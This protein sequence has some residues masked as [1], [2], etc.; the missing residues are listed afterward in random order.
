M[1]RI[2]ISLSILAVLLA[3]ASRAQ[4]LEDYDEFGVVDDGKS[5]DEVAPD[6]GSL[7]PSMPAPDDEAAEAPED[8]DAA[9]DAGAG[10]VVPPTPA[11]DAIARITPPAD[12][13]AV[14]FR[15]LTAALPP[16]FQLGDDADD[17]RMWFL[18]DMATHKGVIFGFTLGSERDIFPDHAEIHVDRAVTL[19]GVAY[20]WREITADLGDG[21]MADLLLL[22]SVDPVDGDESQL[23]TGTTIGVSFEENRQMLETAIGTIRIGTAPPPPETQDGT[24]LDGL[25]IY[26]VPEDWNVLTSQ[27][28]LQ[29]GFW[30]Q[31]YS[32]YIG[33]ARGEAVTGIDGLQHDIPEDIELQ[34]AE[35]L[36]QIADSYYWDGTEDEFQFGGAMVPGMFTYYRLLRCV[37]GDPVMVTLVGARGW[38]WEDEFYAVLDGITLDADKLTSCSR[39]DVGS[40]GAPL[41]QEDIPAAEPSVPVAAPVPAP[42]AAAAAVTGSPVDVGGVTFLLPEGWKVTY[43]TQDD[44]Q[45]VSPDGRW[46]LLSFWWLPDEP[47]LGY[48]DITSVENL[49]L[50]HEPVMR[51]SSWFEGFRTVQTVTERARSDGKRFMFTVEGQSATDSEITS[52]VAALTANLHLQGGFDP[53]KM[54]DPLAAA[55]LATQPAAPSTLA[56][57]SPGGVGRVVDFADG[58]QGWIGDH[59]TLTAERS[60]GPSGGGVLKA[61]APGDGVNGYLIAPPQMLGD[62]V[63]AQGMTVTIRTESGTYVAPFDYGGRGDIY[64]ESRGRTAAIDFP[65]PVG[66][67]WTTEAIRFDAPGWRLSGAA[68]MAELLADVTALHVRIEFLSGDATAW[69]SR[70]ELVGGDAAAALVPPNG[71]AGWT[72]YV[73][74]R[75]GTTIEYPS[76]LLAMQQAPD[77]DDGRTFRSPDGTVTLLV[78]GQ[79]NIDGLDGPAMVARDRD[80]GDYGEVTY[81]SAK[82]DR[83]ALSGYSDDRVFYRAARI[84]NQT[85]VVHV[86][87]IEYPA[88]AKATWDPIVTRLA[89]S[90]RE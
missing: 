78:F 23:I 41:P 80:W 3:P 27:G 38:A 33:I 75:F 15:T 88:A 58:P 87:E 90:F 71:D 17:G 74:A 32:G 66:T 81:Q 9:P 39:D 31:V 51:I 13:Q 37:D 35:V 77:N 83:Y 18:G 48:T 40:A 57:E 25:V 86:F 8:A 72:A 59:A 76:G 44:K 14:S 12:W 22:S 50:D 65:L 62:W 26:S 68:S 69:V 49:V 73:N 24:A 63:G 10:A 1:R 89:K 53:S 43:D 56:D 36:G 21:T 52:V 64:I 46:T 2:L 7:P 6:D 5:L 85:G 70:I 79:Y 29:V 34:A 82:S 55:A 61:F 67:A 28:G 30:P 47:L 19:D 45:F 84:D 42:G 16:E 54:V 60:G 4:D 11:A 20:R